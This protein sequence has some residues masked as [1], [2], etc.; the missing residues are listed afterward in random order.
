MLEETANLKLSNG[1]VEAH[2]DW[3]NKIAKEIESQKGRLT[4]KEQKKYKL[5]LLLRLAGRVDSLS[6]LCGQ[7]QLSQQ[8][9]AQLSRGLWEVSLM[10]KEQHKSYSKT[11]NNIVKHLR[12]EHKLVT[13]GQYSGMWGGIGT[14]I[15]V[16][17]GAASGAGA[18]NTA[19]GLPIGIGI[20]IAVGRY[21]DNK[22]KKEGRVI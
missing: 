9:I 6:S 16:A 1:T 5:D 13:E 17:I 19:I 7:C 11:I 3:Y 21:L 14:A 20:G 4:E 10:S 15:G 2:S 12:K 22:A 18:G 8:D